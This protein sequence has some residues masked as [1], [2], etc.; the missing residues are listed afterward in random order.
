MFNNF[1]IGGCYLRVNPY[2]EKIMRPSFERETTIPTPTTIKQPKSNQSRRTT[3]NEN[4]NANKESCE[5]RCWLFE[6][7]NK[8]SAYLICVN[9]PSDFF[10]Q[11]DNKSNREGD[12]ELVYFCIVLP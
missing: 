4:E 3:E 8:Y 12:E 6:I 10:I 7:G 11:L 9:S 1:Q 2:V 5:M